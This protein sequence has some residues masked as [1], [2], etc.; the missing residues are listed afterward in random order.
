MHEPQHL[1]LVKIY[2]GNT[3]EEVVRSCLVGPEAFGLE[4]ECD[5]RSGVVAAAL[6]KAFGERVV[7][8]LGAIKGV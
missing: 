7:R 3:V 8:R 2:S 6:H 4:R 1:R 5:E